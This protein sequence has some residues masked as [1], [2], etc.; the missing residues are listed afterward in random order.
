MRRSK[1]SKNHA[2]KLFRSKAQRAKLLNNSTSMRG[3]IRL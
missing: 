1:M 3:G 2:R